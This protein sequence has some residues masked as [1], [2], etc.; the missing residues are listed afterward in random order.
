ML[1]SG[2][3]QII[4]TATNKIYIGS[5][6][7][8]KS[9]EWQHFNML[10]RNKHSSQKLQKSYNKHGKNNFKFEVIATCPIEYLIKLEQHFLDTLNPQYNICLI[11]ANYKHQR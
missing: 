8:F 5:T 10:E 11:A 9:R 2:I 4:N 7:D 1:N 3:Y 6:K